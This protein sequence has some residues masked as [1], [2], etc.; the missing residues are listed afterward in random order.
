MV[1]EGKPIAEIARVLDMTRQTVYGAL[2]K[3]ERKE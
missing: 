1:G 2:G 3:W